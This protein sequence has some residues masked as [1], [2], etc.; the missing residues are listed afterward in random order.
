M[1]DKS[2][3]T[4]SENNHNNKDKN[5]EQNNNK[6]NN[7]SGLPTKQQLSV[8]LKRYSSVQLYNLESKNKEQQN[9]IVI[10]SDTAK[11]KKP[12][13]IDADAGKINEK[14]LMA[15][16]HEANSVTNKTNNK[17]KLEG[18]A[19]LVHRVIEAHKKLLGDDPYKPNKPFDKDIE[20]ISD[21]IPNKNS[22]KNPEQNSDKN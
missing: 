14:I 21:E 4:K 12:I 10:Q 1:I 5:Q 20:L 16:Q 2:N 11:F 8:M 18:N 19:S 9:S 3:K 7:Q 15:L 22:D 6:T 17:I 13:F